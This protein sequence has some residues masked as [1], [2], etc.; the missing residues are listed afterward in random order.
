MLKAS[1]YLDLAFRGFG[2]MVL[3]HKDTTVDDIG[4][5]HLSSHDIRILNSLMPADVG[6]VVLQTCNR[7]EI[8]FPSD[9]ETI[10]D[11][12]K[13][14]L[15]SVGK[16]V[17]DSR[18]RVLTGR[19]VVTHLFRVAAGLESLSVGEN[20][21]LG[22]VRDA[23]TQ[24]HRKRAD[25]RLSFLFERALHV[26][27]RVRAETSI[28]K[29]KTGV[30]SLAVA[31]SS[32]KVGLHSSKIAVI[33]AG[34]VGSKVVKMLYDLS[35]KD[36]TIINRTVSTARRLAE[37]YNY[38]FARLNF[39]SLSDYDVV[40]SAINHPSKKR[41]DGPRMVVDLS[42]P[43][44]FVGEN[45]VYLEELKEMAE[46]SAES[47]KQEVLMA[48]GIIREEEETLARKMQELLAD[49]YIG[50]IMNRIEGIR[51]KELKRA[52]SMLEHRGIQR[53]AYLPVLDALTRSI[54]NK[55][56]YRVLEDIRILT[57]QGDM[58]H[59]EYLLSLFGGSP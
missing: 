59:V 18:W 32:K 37:K 21:I 12:L 5:N 20:E 49:K 11:K 22:Q 13:Y 41:A 8:Y 57:Y 43:P 31:Y 26:G 14:Y 36:V 19:E 15:T 55:T 34:D 52:V 7:V 40:F 33:G 1:A 30:Y 9:Q 35:V 16:N 10:L 3:T 6:L 45:V 24:W 4:F 56:F 47:K 46:R 2:A 27:K 50:K 53:D 44:V 25:Q 29:G 23:Y 51:H 42:V 58:D 39:N 48:E 54:I 28:S 17:D 38:D